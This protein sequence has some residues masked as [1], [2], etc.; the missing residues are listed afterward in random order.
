MEEF[1]GVLFCGGRGTRISS[2]TDY[3]SKSFIPVYD[4]PVF[5]FGLSS[6]EDR[7]LLMKLSFSQIL[8]M[9]VNCHD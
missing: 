1:L 5:K 7:N 4:K 6:L 2:L 9:T 8:T 3:I